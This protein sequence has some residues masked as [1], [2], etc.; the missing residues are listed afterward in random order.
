MSLPAS[1]QKGVLATWEDG[2]TDGIGEWGEGLLKFLLRL[3]TFCSGEGSPRQIR[4]WDG[5]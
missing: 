5:G 4:L 3:G 2:E 1:R